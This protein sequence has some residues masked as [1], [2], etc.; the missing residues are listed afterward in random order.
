MN[1]DPASFTRKPTDPARGVES[2]LWLAAGAAWA[3]VAL[4]AWNQT[5]K[6]DAR[7]R[8]LAIS[9]RLLRQVFPHGIRR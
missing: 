2:L 4:R 3:I 9:D 5:R 7:R 1:R 8:T 6:I